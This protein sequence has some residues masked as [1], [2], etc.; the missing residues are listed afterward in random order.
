M[1]VGL[2]GAGIGGIFYLLCALA[3]PVK[4][5]FFTL[6]KPTHKFQYRLVTMQLSIVAGIVSGV[7]IVYKLANNV[8]G[9]DL[10]LSVRTESISMIFYSLLPVLITFGLL[11]VILTLVQLAAFFSSLNN[12]ILKNTSVPQIT[13]EKGEG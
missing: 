5:V 4:E 9:F 3:T 10:S 1:N 2:P 11:L 8:F 12:K 7:I 13:S 6:T